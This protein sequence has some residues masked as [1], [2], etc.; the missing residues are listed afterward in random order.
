LPVRLLRLSLIV[1]RLAFPFLFAA[2]L[3]LSGV[4]V[5]AA[6]AAGGYPLF[7]GLALGWMVL[8]IFGMAESNEPV[9]RGM[10]WVAGFILIA[11]WAFMTPQSI[12]VS[13]VPPT[14]PMADQPL[15]FQS[16]DTP[17]PILWAGERAPECPTL[18]QDKKDRPGA[19]GPEPCG[20][21]RQWFRDTEY[22]PEAWD[23][24]KSGLTRV[25]GTIGIDGRVSDCVI[26]QG[27]GS[28][29]LDETT[30]RL[31]RE[32]AI[33]MPARDAKGSP[34]PSRFVGGVDWRLEESQPDAPAP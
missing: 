17:P 21:M 12:P 31:V 19:V 9:R 33:F 27:S 11:F 16:P 4:V 20:T 6:G 28:L 1:R 25:R 3:G 26:L 24:Q 7:L 10:T 23:H 32:R 30:C 5:R 14:V 13:V 22:P 2:A 34:V 29:S 18:R 8:R 15:S